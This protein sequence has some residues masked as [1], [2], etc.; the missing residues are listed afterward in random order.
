MQI[1]VD[2]EVEMA[3]VRSFSIDEDDNTPDTN[4]AWLK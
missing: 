3:P 4:D 2:L 1:D